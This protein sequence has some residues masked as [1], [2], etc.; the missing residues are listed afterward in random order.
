MSKTELELSLQDLYLKW[1]RDE[2]Y[3]W[4]DSISYEVRMQFIEASIKAV[5]NT[6]AY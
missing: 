3:T 2:N 4:P 6:V 5:F 1:L